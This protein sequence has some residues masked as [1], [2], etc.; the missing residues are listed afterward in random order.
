MALE[1]RGVFLDAAATRSTTTGGAAAS[2]ASGSVGVGKV[3]DVVAVIGDGRG[4]G[5][6]VLVDAAGCGWARRGFARAGRA[7]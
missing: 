6:A 4:A 3:E 1:C 7:G 5:A 2:I